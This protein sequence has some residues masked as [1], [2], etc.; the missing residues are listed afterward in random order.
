MVDMYNLEILESG[1][2]NP[3]VMSNIDRF[4]PVLLHYTAD[5]K[6]G[7]Y[8]TSRKISIVA[9]TEL[10]RIVASATCNRDDKFDIVVGL[11][12]AEAKVVRKYLRKYG[13]VVSKKI[14]TL[15]KELNQTKLLRNRITTELDYIDER[16]QYNLDR[17][18]K[19]EIQDVY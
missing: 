7:I 17:L 1:S 6:V 5:V 9:K 14:Q 13:D 2:T 11:R 10:G 16:A 18:V 19:P 8:E 15:S 4:I 3:V 12:I